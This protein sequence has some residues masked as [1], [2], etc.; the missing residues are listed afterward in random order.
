MVIIWSGEVYS[1]SDVVWSPKSISYHT[2]VHVH[3]ICIYNL[4]NFI[5]FDL[6]VLISYMLRPVTHAGDRLNT[7]ITSS[8]F[9][10]HSITICSS[11]KVAKSI[12]T[13]IIGISICS[14]RVNK[15]GLSG[16]AR[17]YGMSNCT[18]EN[19]RGPVLGPQ[20]GQTK[21]VK[22]GKIKWPNSLRNRQMEIRA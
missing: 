10:Y 11:G 4:T 15:S 9:S 18:Q 8:F 22:C 12:F 14:W 13:I 6:W 3:A 20:L 5:I 21:S 2:E 19:P 17:P 7:L 16:Y 1:P